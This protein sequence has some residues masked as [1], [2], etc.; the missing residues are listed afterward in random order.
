MTSVLIGASKM[1]PIE[2]AVGILNNLSF[3]A[4]NCSPVIPAPEGD[5]N[6]G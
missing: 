3:S 1:A 2:D 5:R 6:D 4:G